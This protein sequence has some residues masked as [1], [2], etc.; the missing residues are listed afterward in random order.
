[1]SLLKQLAFLFGL[2]ACIYASA[3][4]L[5]RFTASPKTLPQTH[6]L[7]DKNPLMIQGKDMRLRIPMFSMKMCEDLRNNNPNQVCEPITPRTT[8]AKS[9]N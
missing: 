4:A 1:M 5:N 2:F 3:G 6:V 9:A 7:K 8:A